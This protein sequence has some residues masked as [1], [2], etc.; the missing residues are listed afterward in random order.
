VSSLIRDS[1]HSRAK[2]T[3]ERAELLINYAGRTS[4]ATG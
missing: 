4:R 1:A 3:R 2:S